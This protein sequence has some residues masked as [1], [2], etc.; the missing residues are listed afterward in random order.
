[1]P[2]KTSVMISTLPPG[3]GE[4]L[5]AVSFILFVSDHARTV[6][7]HRFGEG[8]ASDLVFLS[9]APVCSTDFESGSTKAGAGNSGV[10]VWP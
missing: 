4:S 9:A 6:L 3:A 8:L 5:E 7:S 2:K 1:M 10:G